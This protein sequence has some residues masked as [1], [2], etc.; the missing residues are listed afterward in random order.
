MIRDYVKQ[1]A[2]A[3]YVIN[4]NSFDKPEPSISLSVHIAK[5][6]TWV[7]EDNGK[8]VGF[9][10]ASYSV[11]RPYIY[12]LAVLPEYRKIG[13]GTELIKVFETHFKGKGKPYLHVN[14]N[15]PARYLYEKLGY[16]IE[17]RHK[18]FYS[19]GQDAL[20]MVKEGCGCN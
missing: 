8:V 4:N 18:N 9:L 19:Q 11:D 6:K 14:A 15:N 5:G 16:K 3:I 2:T 20:I 17:A 13:I 1:D 12:N 10:I 7:A